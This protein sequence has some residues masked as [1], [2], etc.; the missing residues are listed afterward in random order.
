M[1][2]KCKITPVHA[3]FAVKY[4]LFSCLLIYLLHDSSLFLFD[5]CVLWKKKMILYRRL[6]PNLMF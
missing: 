4:G 3:K 5:S 1:N 6:G 2:N